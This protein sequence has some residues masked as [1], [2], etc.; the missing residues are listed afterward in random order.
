MLRPYP[1]QAVRLW[2]DLLPGMPVVT[3]PF[4]TVTRTIRRQRSWRERLFS[5]PWR[6]T[7][8]WRMVTETVPDPSI[9]ILNGRGGYRYIYCH[10]ATAKRLEELLAEGGA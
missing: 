2:G 5:R 7:R 3:S 4:V 9:Y 10:P 8:K 6:P 1:L